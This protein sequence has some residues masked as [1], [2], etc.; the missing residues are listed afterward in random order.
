MSMSRDRSEVEIWCL[1]SGI[2]QNSEKISLQ[3]GGPL[4]LIILVR[5]VRT[6]RKGSAARLHVSLLHDSRSLDRRFKHGLRVI[7]TTHDMSSAEVAALTNAGTFLAEGG[8]ETTLIYKYGRSLKDFASFTMLLNKEDNEL[9][10][11]IHKSY[12]DVAIKH[13]L[14]MLLDIET[15]RA[16]SRWYAKVGISEEEQGKIPQLAF[17]KAKEVT[18]YIFE[19][20]NGK[21]NAII[22]GVIGIIVFTLTIPGKLPSGESLHD[23]VTRIDSETG[24]SVLYFGI[25]CTHPRYIYAALSSVKGEEWLERIGT[26]RG[27]A[28]LK[29]HEELDTSSELDEGDPVEFAKEM[30][31]LRE[32]L[33][34]LKVIG[35]CCGTSSAH[36]EEIAKL[37]KET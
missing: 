34:S 32:V 3:N 4:N 19:K 25:N 28:S 6:I 8:L 12:A 2:F 17:D 22:N 36:C 31:A 7:Y 15:W 20:S 11:E 5:N 21:S 9:L 13:E 37:I 30:V 26:V 23:A 16:S 29:S 27:N 18:N 14:P 1:I 10:T 24:N 35:G 33:P